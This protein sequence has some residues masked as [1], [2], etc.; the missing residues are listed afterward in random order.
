MEACISV[1]TEHFPLIEG[2]LL[3][4][5]TSVL[6]GSQADF[7]S[8]EDVY[9]AVGP[10][11]SEVDQ[12]KSEDEVQDICD[13]LFH[14]LK[15]D[16]DEKDSRKNGPHRILDAPVHLGKL[17]EDSADKDI[18]EANIW[19]AKKADSTIVDQKKLEKAEAKLKQK[20]EKRS[21]QESVPRVISSD[22]LLQ[23][24]SASQQTNRKD[25]KF[26]S[27]GANRSYDIRI[28]NFDISYG[29]LVLIKGASINMAFGRRYGLVG[30]NGKGKTTLL[31]MIASRQL[32]IASHITILHVEQEVVGDDTIA[33]DS[34][35]QSDEKRESLLR[36]ER[37]ITAKINSTSPNSTEDGLSTRLTEVYAQL[38][39]MEAEKAPARAAMILSGLGFTPQM[40]RST[41]KEFSGGWRMRLA[42][43]RALFAKP[44]L[45]LLDE[46]TNMLDMKA[47]IW[48]ENY[49]QTWPTTILVVSHD[50]EFLNSVAT[51]IMHLFSQEID[52]YKGNFENFVKT[53]TEKI[54][55]QRKEYEAQMQYREHVQVFIDKF[56]YN[57]KR[58]SLVQSKIKLLEK[59]PVLKPVEKETDI[60]FRFPDVESLSPPIL[61]LDEV[62]FYYTKEKIIFKN[63]CVSADMESRICVVGE[64][65][66]GKTTL[67]KILLGDLSPTKGFRHIHRNLKIGYFSQ[68]HVDQLDMNQCSV[69]VLA[70]KYPGRNTEEYRHQLGSFGLSGDLAMQPVVSLSGGQKSRV[71]F[72]LLAMGNPNFFIL[73][74]PTNHLDMETIEALGNA[75]NKFKGG[76]VLVSHDER[77]IR[78]IC[79]ELWVCGK[80]TVKSLEGGFD[81]YKK[82]VE[83][84]LAAQQ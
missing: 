16:E 64:N 15:G 71:A 68:H 41:T 84:E 42:L 34:V 17:V 21:D 80:G 8:N 70:S 20:Q 30:K 18:Q 48:L 78:M 36:E 28:D 47:I 3:Q 56:R 13:K 54:K 57:A 73:D 76:V 7:E 32:K 2:E 35:L 43:A 4:Y 44:D 38:E 39:A 81:E 6:E 72:A 31:R 61:Q 46:P 59:L 10:V 24:A 27:S 51:D 40:Q 66:A 29:S 67:L 55:N 23:A 19:I 65:G 58:A 50:R 82:I 45:L 5:V 33:V 25:V 77:L 22:D 14:M 37:E 63:V 49:L 1:I 52:C 12:D 79:K 11:L 83:A 60:V 75:I 62:D 74:E 69:E 26:D 53:R 9:E